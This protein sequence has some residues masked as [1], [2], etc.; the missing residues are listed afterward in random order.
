MLDLKL[1]AFAKGSFKSEKLRRGI[2]KKKFFALSF[3][4]FGLLFIQICPAFA[5]WQYVESEGES[6]LVDES[7]SP[8]AYEVLWDGKDYNSERVSCGGYLY[9]LN[10]G[11][12]SETKK[13]VLMK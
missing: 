5:S 10:A 1:H 2:M 4:L 6:T 13:M 3:L 9:R 7:K 11:E 12:L 8:G